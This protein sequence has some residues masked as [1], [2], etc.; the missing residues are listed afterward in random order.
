MLLT[1]QNERND[2]SCLRVACYR[3]VALSALLLL[4]YQEISELHYR[5]LHIITHVIRRVRYV[6]S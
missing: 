6:I 3:F 2:G 1:F 4:H 5:D